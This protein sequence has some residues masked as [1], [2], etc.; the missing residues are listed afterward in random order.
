M[1]LKLDLIKWRNKSNSVGFIMGAAT[2]RLARPV[3]KVIHL[4][5][6]EDTYPVCPRCR[7]SMDREYISFCDRCGQKLSWEHWGQGQIIAEPFHK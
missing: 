3:T 7:I 1:H 6:S 2:Y 4:A 5:S